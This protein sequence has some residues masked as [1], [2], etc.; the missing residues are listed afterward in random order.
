[1]VKSKYIRVVVPEPLRAKFQHTYN[2][3]FQQFA[4]VKDSSKPQ[5]AMHLAS[6]TRRL[7]GGFCFLF[8]KMHVDL[9]CMEQAFESVNS[10]QLYDVD[11]VDHK[12]NHS[13]NYYEFF[14]YKN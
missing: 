12:Y 9:A 1:M 11:I 14:F 3:I 5:A 7:D 10:L 8:Y 4:T 2:M 13:L 6:K